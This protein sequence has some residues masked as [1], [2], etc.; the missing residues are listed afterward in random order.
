PLEIRQRV[1]DRAEGNPLFVEEVVRM[2]I[3][4][5]VVERQGDRW[6]AKRE[7]ADIRVPENV[8]ALIRAR[9]DTLPTSER[10][11][12]QA[13]SVVGR[14]FQQSAVAA[15]APSTEGSTLQQHL[16]DAILRDLITDERVHDE[17]TFRFRH[18]LIRDVA[19]ATLPKARRADLHRGVADWLR[20]W[21]GE[22]IEEF[23]EIEAYH[24]EQSVRLRWELDGAIDPAER[25]RAVTALRSSAERAFARDDARATRTFAERA[26][27]L[28]LPSGDERLEIQALL[29]E[30]LW[31]LSEYRKSG[32]VASKL[33]IEA[34]TA[35]R[36]D[37]QGRA[38]L[39]KAGDIWLRLESADADVALRELERARPL[40]DEAGDRRA[41]VFA[42]EL[43]GWAG[44]WHGDLER[45]RVA[46]VQMR[47]LAHELGWT[48]REAEAVMQ[49]VGIAAHRGEVEE[50]R[51]LMDAARAL[52][53]SGPSRLTRARVDRA[54]GTNLGVLG[55]IGEG[56]QLLID[57]GAI[58][59]EF[60]DRDEAFTANLHLGD[61]SRMLGRPHEALAHYERAETQVLEHAGFL[62]EALRH[63]AQ[64]LIGIGDLDRAVEHAERAVAITGR[65]D[66]ATVASTR[67]VLGMVREAQGRLGE[68]EDL[69]REAAE[70]MDRLDFNPWEEEIALAEFLLRRGRPDEASEW[71]EKARAS[72]VIFGPTSPFSADVEAR[73]AAASAGAQRA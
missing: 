13:A 32:D 23:A 69:L 5:G 19:Y 48:S 51:A 7:A 1:L 73:A 14:I 65:D 34:A 54:Y 30:A 22:R 46:F 26:L 38:I 45:S 67:M 27:A 17:P 70:V 16:E 6:V 12:V 24:L 35:G 42:H 18:I 25:D 33:E 39:F 60:G 49:L 11:T 29:A 36:K 2:L 43:M 21:A 63:K 40:L 66:W 10:A 41:L 68:A 58:L 61:F 64:V 28:D 72:V 31:R 4:E 55:Q 56:I 50:C 9:L 53:A 52:A 59:E 15:I 3:E 37:L 57:A 62:P 8:E 20:A 71:L 44:W 47:E